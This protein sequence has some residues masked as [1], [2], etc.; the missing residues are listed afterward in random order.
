MTTL[1]S[2]DV[3]FYCAYFDIY[4]KFVV[5]SPTK[6]PTQML[7]RG[8]SIFTSEK[9]GP[10]LVSFQ[11]IFEALQFQ[12]QVLFPGMENPKNPRIHPKYIKILH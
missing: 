12:I 3:K 11:M 5:G 2:K 4:E 8:F 10:T 1:V 7:K 9:I 6:T